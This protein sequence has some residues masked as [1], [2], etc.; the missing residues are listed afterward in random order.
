MYRGANRAQLHAHH[1][2]RPHPSRGF[3][4]GPADPQAALPSAD[5]LTFEEAEA[6]MERLR[7]EL[8]R[9]DHD[10]TAAKARGVEGE[11]RFLGQR[12]QSIQARII[13]IKARIKTLARKRAH[14]IDDWRKAVHEI[15]DPETAARIL[16]RVIE[17]QQEES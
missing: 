11:I 8:S 10:L 12:H 7:A 17:L 6:E 1:V 14:D 13:P 4:D 15:A 9:C 2:G 3:I 5:S 16:A